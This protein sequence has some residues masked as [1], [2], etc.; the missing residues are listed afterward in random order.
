MELRAEKYKDTY[1]DALRD[2]IDAKRKGKQIHAAAE[3]DEGESPADLMEALRQSISSAKRG[4]SKRTPHTKA[5]RNDD[6]NS[7]TKDELLRLA[8][9]AKIS[10]RSQMG[11]AEL[12]K[13]LRRAA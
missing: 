10:G 12:V 11:K 5:K 13:A 8:Q 2:V 4:H 1:R 9:R 7:K 6:L 3:V